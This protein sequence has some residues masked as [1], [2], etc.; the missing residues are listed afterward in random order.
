M[1][2]IDELKTADDHRSEIRALE[3]D[4]E[5]KVRK[6]VELL[7]AMWIEHGAGG[8]PAEMVDDIERLLDLRD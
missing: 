3:A 8:L 6:V 4:C 2:A 7:E 1:K 5:R